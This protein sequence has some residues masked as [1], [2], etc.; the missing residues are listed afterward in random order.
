MIVLIVIFHVLNHVLA[1][2]NQ[3]S[4]S[5][6]MSMCLSR[7]IS[8]SPCGWERSVFSASSSAWIFLTLSSSG[9]CFCS[10]D[11]QNFTSS[12]SRVLRLTR[13]QLW[14]RSKFGSERINVVWSFS[15]AIEREG[16]GEGGKEGE[17][18]REGEGERERER[19][20]KSKKS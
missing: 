19:E 7:D 8:S 12:H 10:I 11:E 14:V 2:H 13:T 6:S 4:K 16:E 9:L 18:G 3:S 1:M 20:E 5:S 17:G 15:P